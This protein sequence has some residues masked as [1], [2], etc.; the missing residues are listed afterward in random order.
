MITKVTVKWLRD[1]ALATRGDDYYFLT[2]FPEG[3]T[4]RTLEIRLKPDEWEE[5]VAILEEL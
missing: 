5:I 3:K 1:K 2:D 4:P